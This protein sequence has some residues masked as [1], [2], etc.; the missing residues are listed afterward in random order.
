MGA[1]VK[2]ELSKIRIESTGWDSNPRFRIT[3]AESSPLNDQCNWDQRDLNPH[4][5][6]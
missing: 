5:L 3:G 2:V 1:I 6:G 4:L